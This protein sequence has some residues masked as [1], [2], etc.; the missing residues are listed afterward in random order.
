MGRPRARSQSGVS[1]HAPRSVA[2][3]EPRPAA[4]NGQPHRDRAMSQGRARPTRPSTGSREP[5]SFGWVRRG[6]ALQY[7]VLSATKSAGRIV[8]VGRL[9]ICSRVVGGARSRREALRWMPR[10]RLLRKKPVVHPVEVEPVEVG[11]PAQHARAEH[12]CPRLAPFFVPS[13]PQCWW[14]RRAVHRA[15]LVP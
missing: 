14:P 15:N 12:Q 9:M 4:Q 6:L 8:Y 5:G 13:C 2:P 7:L 1:V 3:S 10:R 11:P